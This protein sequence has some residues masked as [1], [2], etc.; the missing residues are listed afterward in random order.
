MAKG[1]LSNHVRNI[2]FR[3]GDTSRKSNKNRPNVGENGDDDMD[4]LDGKCKKSF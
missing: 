4:F 3:S 1:K 2:L